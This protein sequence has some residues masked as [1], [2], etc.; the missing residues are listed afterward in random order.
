[1][2]SQQRTSEQQ[3]DALH[4]QLQQ[5]RLQ[6][7]SRLQH[8]PRPWAA[9]L[10]VCALAAGVI[11]QRSHSISTAG[12]LRL[13]LLTLKIGAPNAPADLSDSSDLAS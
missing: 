5:Q 6:L 4:R 1:M 10:A 9:G 13:G 11:C 7:K 8:S 3:I 12:L 2:N